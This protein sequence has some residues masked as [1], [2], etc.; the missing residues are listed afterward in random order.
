MLKN[1]FD[2]GQAK[3]HGA[4]LKPITPMSHQDRI[5]PYISIQY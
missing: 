4:S 5:S 3:R 2:G 1:N